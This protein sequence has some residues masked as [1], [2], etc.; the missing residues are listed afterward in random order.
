MECTYNHD[1][2]IYTVSF[3]SLSGEF[4]EIQVTP[5]RTYDPTD[6]ILDYSF[7]SNGKEV[8]IIEVHTT[9]SVSDLLFPDFDALKEA[10]S[11]VCDDVQELIISSKLTNLTKFV[12]AKAN[13]KEVRQIVLYYGLGLAIGYRKDDN[14]KVV[15]MKE[16][17]T[18]T[19]YHPN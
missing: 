9:E 4:N 6:W 5:M 15:P 2:G 7:K 16:F 19:C 8:A 18:R 13:A 17:P 10:Q 12:Q 14:Q 3:N 1:S 11:K